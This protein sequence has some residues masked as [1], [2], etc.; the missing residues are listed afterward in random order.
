MASL[1]ALTRARLISL[2]QETIRAFGDQKCTIEQVAQAALPAARGICAAYYDSAI[3]GWIKP[4]ARRLMRKTV[5]PSGAPTLLPGLVL[6]YRIAVPA[7][8]GMENYEPPDDDDEDDE[9]GDK[10][11]L[12]IP[13][14]LCSI[15]EG[16]RNLAL[17]LNLINRSQAEHDKIKLVVD[18]AA[19]M[20]EDDNAIIGVVLG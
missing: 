14:H 20:T 19:S 1:K 13:L 16:R 8:R 10:G 12:W 6:P 2:I 11:I 5:A 15:A 17:R 9:E 18:E 4:I 7:L 3:A